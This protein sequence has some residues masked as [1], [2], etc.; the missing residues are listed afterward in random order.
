[1]RDERLNEYS[2][3]N[4]KVFISHALETKFL[5]T[6][7]EFKLISKGDKI[8]V[9]LSGGVD[10]VVLLMLLR[11]YKEK[12][13]IDILAVHVNHLVR[14]SS[15][16]DE[17]F[18][19]ELC[20]KINVPILVFRY[21]VKS[22]ASTH[23]LS[24]EEAGRVIRYK[25]FER[26]LEEKHFDKIATAHHVDDNI[27]TL[28]FRLFKNPSVQGLSSIRPKVGCIIRPLIAITKSEILEYASQNGIE[29]VIDETNLL[30]DYDRNYIRNSIIPKIQDRFP[31]FRKKI[32]NVIRDFWQVNDLFEKFSLKLAK[33]Y[34]ISKSDGFEISV[35]LFKRYPS[36][37]SGYVLKNLFSSLGVKV[38]RKIINTII[39]QRK[40]EG[41]KVLLNIKD[42]IVLR[43]YGTV[44]ILR[45][46]KGF[47]EVI[48]LQLNGFSIK[49]MFDVDVE[50]FEVEVDEEFISRIKV[51][52]NTGVM[53][54]NVT[55]TP[56]DI[57]IR[58]RR[59]GDYIQ[60]SIGK[61]K[62]K[63][64]LID[65]K[66]PLSKREKVVVVEVGGK[67][68]G[69]YYGKVRVSKDFNL[70]IGKNLVCKLSFRSL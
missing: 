3:D 31:Y 56:K 41:N 64:I 26:V 13:G 15:V 23:K 14:E 5:Q 22:F 24:V 47:S 6:I 66:I 28:L 37:L 25:F 4:F 65:E 1:M 19:V 8:V 36:V 60:M 34:V 32:Y 43:E 70:V 27:E 55:S 52:S 51:E 30:E 21:D 44:N 33:K 58:H 48:S 39:S 45:K 12:F 7:K 54:I 59:N 16:R 62:I 46:A 61:K 2:D 49:S 68:A 38:N 9:G 40:T 18:C 11:K 67:V 63:D 10:S 35:D 17:N 57:L 53:Y 20:N 42:V 50:I 29:F 69:F